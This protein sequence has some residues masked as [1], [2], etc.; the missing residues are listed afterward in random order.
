[1][2]IKRNPQFE[3][4]VMLYSLLTGHISYNDS[5]VPVFEATPKGYPFPYVVVGDCQWTNESTKDFYEEEYTIN[6]DVFT[7]YGGTMDNCAILDVVYQ[8]IGAAFVP[9]PTQFADP[10]SFC[11]TMFWFGN[12][13]TKNLAEERRER[14]ELE[15]SQVELVFRIKQIG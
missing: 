13:W 7:A 4:R 3:L 10:T 2:M 11:V 15:Q 8:L 1:M 6:I 14:E 5:I 9:D 12:S